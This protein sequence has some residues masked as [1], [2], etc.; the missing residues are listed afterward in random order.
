[1]RAGKGDQRHD[2][3]AFLTASHHLPVGAC[4][5]AENLERPSGEITGHGRLPRQTGTRIAPNVQYEAQITT[6]G[7]EKEGVGVL[8]MPTRLRVENVAH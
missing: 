2:S 1:M 6:E 8:C 7:K 4:R 3:S 5:P